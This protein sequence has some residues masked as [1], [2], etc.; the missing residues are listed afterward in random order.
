MSIID[1]SKKYWISY[2]RRYDL[3][4]N[5]LDKTFEEIE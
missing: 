3:V 4:K 1:Q 5:L 2:I